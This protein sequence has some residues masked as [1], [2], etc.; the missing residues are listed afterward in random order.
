MGE[1]LQDP[2]EEDEDEVRSTTAH[3]PS[4]L[5]PLPTEANSTQ[6]GKWLAAEIL[7]NQEAR[8]AM[9][10]RAEAEQS[11]PTDGSPFLPRSHMTETASPRFPRAPATNTSTP[12]PLATTPRPP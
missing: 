4:A 2:E 7:R 6:R 5:V 1:L 3:P 11:M 10:K 9:R 8:K 12:T